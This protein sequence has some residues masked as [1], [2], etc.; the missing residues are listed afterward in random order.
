[1]FKTIKDYDNAILRV[2]T[3]VRDNNS[4]PEPTNELNEIDLGD[5]FNLCYQRGY[6]DGIIVNKTAVGHYRCD[7]KPR[8]TYQGLNFIESYNQ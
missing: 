8:I 3:F 2:L 1:M 7:G 5:V 4:F 6:I